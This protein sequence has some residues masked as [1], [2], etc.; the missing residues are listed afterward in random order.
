MDGGALVAGFSASF[1]FSVPHF[2]HGSW[3]DFYQFLL[4][5]SCLMTLAIATFIPNDLGAARPESISLKSMYELLRDP[6]IFTLI[7]FCASIYSG[8][9]YF[10]SNEVFIFLKL[11]SITP[12]GARTLMFASWM[13]YAI[14]CMLSGHF[15]DRLTRP[16]HSLIGYSFACFIC[17]LSIVYLKMRFALSLMFRAWCRGQWNHYCYNGFECSS[18]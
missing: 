16:D 7:V 10:S 12:D 13:G 11:K 8:L 14:G 4:V 5:V 2:W 15:V 9:Q 18:R 3:H 6:Y 17:F 1:A